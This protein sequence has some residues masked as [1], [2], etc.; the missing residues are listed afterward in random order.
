MFT[1]MGRGTP[2]ELEAMEATFI[3]YVQR[4][5]TTGMYR[6]WLACAGDG[7]VVAGGGL[8]VH[9]W[10]ARPGDP[11]TRRAYVL[12]IYTEPGYRRQGL[13]RRIMTTILDWCRAE[14]FQT[15]S[16]HASQDGRPL[17][18]ALGFVPTNEMRLKL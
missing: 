18:E 1:D 6:G 7:R 3:P 13:A 9:E 17:Y 11:N 4:A 8:I 5:L 15:V 2:A 12:N 14:G 10:P 16:L